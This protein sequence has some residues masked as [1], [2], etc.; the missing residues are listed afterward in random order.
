MQ[1]LFLVL[2]KVECLE[3]LLV[4]LAEGGVRGGTI[5]ESTGMARAL[6][7]AEDS[8]FLGS[9]RMLLDPQRE[10]SKTLFFVLRDEQVATVREIINDVTGGLDKPDTG[11]MFGTNLTFVE[12]LGKGLGA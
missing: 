2:N 12:G 8:N 5:I 11:I 9:L 1:I 4:K 10:E 6:G 3:D 7:D